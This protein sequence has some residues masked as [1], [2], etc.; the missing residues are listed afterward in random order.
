[1]VYVSLEG[2]IQNPLL[3]SFTV[4]IST[5]QPSWLIEELG[6]NN[7]FFINQVIGLE[8]LMS[9]YYDEPFEIT[10]AWF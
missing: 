6:W 10:E 7:I 4:S 1:M 5:H 2:W 8:W 9:F 3:T